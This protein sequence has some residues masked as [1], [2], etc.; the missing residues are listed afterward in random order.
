[1]LSDVLSRLLPSDGFGIV[2]VEACFGCHVN[3]FACRFVALDNFAGSAVPV[4]RYDVTI[5]TPKHH[6]KQQNF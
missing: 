6:V 2:D 1:M 5:S 4:F 3:G